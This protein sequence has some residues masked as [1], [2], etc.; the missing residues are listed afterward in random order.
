[1]KKNLR[2]QIILN[3]TF[4]IVMTLWSFPGMFPGGGAYKGFFLPALE[5]R[6]EAAA[7]L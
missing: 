2:L 1:M 7:I 5:D 4:F 6:R 3:Q